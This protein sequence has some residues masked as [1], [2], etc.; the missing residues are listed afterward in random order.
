MKIRTA[1]PLL[2]AMS[3]LMVASGSIAQMSLHPD[4]LDVTLDSSYL[5]YTMNQG[6]TPHYT[7]HGSII[8]F[9]FSG[10][11][12]VDI[13]PT[14]QWII[15]TKI[16]GSSVQSGDMVE[17]SPGQTLPV[18]VMVTPIGE[19]I[20]TE[21]FYLGLA[22]GSKGLALSEII[23]YT[24]NSTSAVNADQPNPNVA[25]VPNPAANYITIRGLTSEQL[26]C[27]Y[28]I[29]SISGAD[30]RHGMLPA[31]ARINVQDLSSGAYRLLLFDGKQAFSNTAIT[32]LH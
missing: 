20:D 1:F 32:I 29:F 30:V 27:R 15:S 21:T 18:E 6:T 25:I 11:F 19:G 24:K 16:N 26:G 22:S 10:S 31:D 9:L 23:L 8:S 13:T 7:V 28:E 2:L 4:D 5:T 12:T 17:I 14:K 3:S